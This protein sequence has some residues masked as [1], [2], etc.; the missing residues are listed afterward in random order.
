[1]LLKSANQVTANNDFGLDD[2]FPAENDV[3][4]AD[5]LRAPGNFVAS[6][7]C[8]VSSRP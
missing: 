6:V 1:M 2:R 7:L 4:G 3:L 5:D 8:S